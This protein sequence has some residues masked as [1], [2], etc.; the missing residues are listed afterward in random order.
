MA[1]RIRTNGSAIPMEA[2]ER[3][4]R[5]VV[6]RSV[7]ARGATKAPVDTWV[8]HTTTW[9]RR[10]AIDPIRADYGEK[11]INHQVVAQPQSVWEMGY[12]ED[13]DPTIYDVAKTYRLL[14]QGRPYNIVAA[15]VIGQR[16]GIEFVAVTNGL[17]P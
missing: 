8:T 2:G 4:C 1:R 15:D 12:R 10:T 11:F 9:M 17:K 5:V 3:T 14:Y 16:E 13:M 7:A 6:Q